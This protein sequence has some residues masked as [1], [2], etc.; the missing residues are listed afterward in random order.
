ML[1]ATLARVS[2]RR[3]AGRLRRS[4][5]HRRC[6][7]RPPCGGR[8]CGGAASR[9]GAGATRARGRRRSHLRGAGR[10]LAASAAGR[11]ARVARIGESGRA[12]RAHRRAGAHAPARAGAALRRSA[13]GEGAGFGAR[14]GALRAVLLRLP[15][16][17][18]LAAPSGTPGTVHG[19]DRPFQSAGNAP[20]Q[21]EGHS[22][23]GGQR[24]AGDGHAF[25]CRRA[26]RRGALGPGLLH[27]HAFPPRRRKPG[28]APLA[29]ANAGGFSAG[30][31][32]A[33]HRHRR[34]PAA[35]VPGRGPEPS[36][37]GAG[38]GGGARGPIRGGG[39]AI[40]L[41]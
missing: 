35:A 32:P 28:C 22:S 4:G 7:A 15:R 5:A 11:G 8:R 17:L 31:A 12:H 6:V 40:A 14:R 38:A 24:S 29:R 21:P 2:G 20:V 27:R 30:R 36:G 16:R 10:P 1:V 33:C 3:C 25:L 34:F 37:C 23:R 41:D 18:G 26:Q 39:R 13:A 19:A 9:S